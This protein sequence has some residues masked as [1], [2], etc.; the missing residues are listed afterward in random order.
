MRLQRIRMRDFKG[1]AERTVAFAA[2]GVTIVEGQNEIGKSALADAL[3]LLLDYQDSSTAQAVRAAK[4]VHHD[5]VP[6][7]EIVLTTSQHTI[8]YAK[9]FASGRKGSTT[10]DVA[11]PE[12]VQLTGVQAHAHAQHLLGSVADLDLWR[13][14]RLQ[15]GTALSQTR[16]GDSASLSRALDAAAGGGQTIGE[17]ETSL[18]ARVE[19]EYARYHTARGTARKERKTL[20]ARV[21]AAQDEVKELER[22]IAELER[23][24]ERTSVLD[25]QLAAMEPKLTHQRKRVEELAEERRRIDRLESDVTELGY[26]TERLERRA[27]QLA[28]QQ[29]E[30]R[31][32]VEDI[33]R[34]TDELGT[35]HDC[36][37]ETARAA[38]RVS[39]G[40]RMTSGRE[41]LARRAKE[42]TRAVRKL[43]EQRIDAMHRHETVMRLESR[44]RRAADA[45]EALDRAEARLGGSAITDAGLKRVEAADMQLI[46]TRAAAAA[47]AGVVSVHAHDGVRITHLG[48]DDAEADQV[49]ELGA[50]QQLEHPA[51]E[52]IRL[53]IGDLATVEVRPGTDALDIRRQLAGAEADLAA[54]LE[55]V[56]V[57]DVTEARA[58][59]RAWHDATGDRDRAA[60]ELQLALDGHPVSTL[61]QQLARLSE[62]LGSVELPP[63]AD[64]DL[65]HA[66]LMQARRVEEQADRELEEIAGELSTLRQQEQEHAQQRAVAR[67]QVEH[68]T[69]RREEVRS[70]LSRLRGERDDDAMAAAVSEAVAEAA[71]MRGRHDTAAERLAVADG[72]S[73]VALHENAEQGLTR[74]EQERRESEDSRRELRATLRMRGAHGLADKLDAAR[75]ELVRTQRECDRTESRARAAALLHERMAAHRDQ[76]RRTYAAPF[77]ERLEQFGR[78]VFGEDFAVTLDEDLTVVTRRLDG[79]TLPHD[80]LSGGAR[81]QL[82]VLARLACA[83]IVASDGGVPLLLDDAL[84]YSDPGRLER[85]GAAFRVGAQQAQVIIMTCVPDRYAHIGDA[86]VVRLS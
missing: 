36:G 31:S 80:R 76:A 29:A 20:E 60:R 69:A 4:P 53:R 86:T 19:Q 61:Q 49:A 14:L 32:C 37:A 58:A 52:P 16:L 72:D 44:L 26:E 30:R 45:Q 56:G 38:T 67:T 3:D 33:Q 66:E 24:V 71:T 50:G 7:V 84:G 47:Q 40:I 25:A 79:V 1:V 64:T 82:D 42:D 54:A 74:L 2:Q 39:E 12:P 35:L 63:G 18:F 10:L 73:V 17:H 5:A 28:G 75:T 57:G 70:H 55:A 83:A 51:T 34:L 41:R 78:I 48:D 22:Q 15:Q 46:Q 9:R 27:G 65:L 85:L 77:R 59:H 43:V 23:D 11:G 21:D 6:E 8:T 68:L 62:E 81:E 13:A